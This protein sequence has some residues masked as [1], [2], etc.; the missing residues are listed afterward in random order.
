MKIYKNCTLYFFSCVAYKSVVYKKGAFVSASRN[1][2]LWN[3][4]KYTIKIKGTCFYKQ[5]KN[6][7]KVHLNNK[8]EL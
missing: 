8:K 1:I 4:L 3:K 2:I 7:G 6:I 5:E